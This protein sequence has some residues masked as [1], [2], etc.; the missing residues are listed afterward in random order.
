MQ[1]LNMYANPTLLLYQRKNNRV[2]IHSK[3]KQKK[4]KHIERNFKF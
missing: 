1:K 3:T 4:F 2:L